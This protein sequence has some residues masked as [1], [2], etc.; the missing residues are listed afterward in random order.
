MRNPGEVWSMPEGTN[1]KLFPAA[2]NDHEQEFAA[3]LGTFIGAPAELW[4]DDVPEALQVSLDARCVGEV[5][6]P[7]TPTP[8]A[9][10]R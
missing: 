5:L 1:S 2:A 9:A 10:P 3:D 7:S 6:A 8:S 4:R